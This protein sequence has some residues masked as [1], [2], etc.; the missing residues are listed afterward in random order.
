ME[1]LNSDERLKKGQTKRQVPFLDSQGL[2][3]PK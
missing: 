3:E 2:D 1:A